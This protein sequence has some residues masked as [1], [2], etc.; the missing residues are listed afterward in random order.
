M[1]FNISEKSSKI[2]KN[3]LKPPNLT[4]IS[5]SSNPIHSSKIIKNPQK[6]TKIHQNPQ[7]SSKIQK[8]LKTLKIRSTILI[9]PGCLPSHFHKFYSDKTAGF[10]HEIPERRI[11]VKLK[12]CTMP[13]FSCE[14]VYFKLLRKCYIITCS[15]TC[16]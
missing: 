6:S 7:I 12:I 3:P 13:I 15:T 14:S 10:S 5:H 11:S 9:F 2:P 8:S 1:L 4:N 16:F